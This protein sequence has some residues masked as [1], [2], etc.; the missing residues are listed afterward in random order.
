MVSGNPTPEQQD[1]S[2]QEP[3]DDLTLSLDKLI[4]EGFEGSS[5][6]KNLSPPKIGSVKFFNPAKWQEWTRIFIVFALLANLFFSI[7]VVRWFIVL[8]SRTSQ[9]TNNTQESTT[10]NLIDLGEG[11]Y[12]YILREEATEQV[13]QEGEIKELLILVWTSQVTL[14]SGVLGFYFASKD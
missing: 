12:L 9:E 2:Q 3:G 5:G 8:S 10:D 4:I 14:I 13:D 1:T 7:W 11:N 6:A